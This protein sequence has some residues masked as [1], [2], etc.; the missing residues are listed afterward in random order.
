VRI[1][2]KNL[3]EFALIERLLR[4]VGRSGPPLPL[5]AGDDAALMPAL[6]RGRGVFTTDTMIENVHFRRDTAPPLALGIKALEASLSDLA[7]MGARPIAFFLSLSLPRR[8]PMADFDLLAT[9]LSRSARRARV[10]LAGG[11][12]TASPGPLVIS[13]GSLGALRRRGCLR[14]DGARPGDLLAVTGPL[15]ASATGLR[16]LSEGWRWGA[17][18][19]SGPARSP[20]A[21]RHARA[22]LRAHL[23]PRARLD[24]GPVAAERGWCRAGLDLSD[25][26]ASDLRRLCARS[27]VGARIE[28]RRVPIAPSARYWAGRWRVDPLQ[29]ALG[30]GEDYELLLALRPAAL[31]RWRRAG[32]PPPPLVLG[33]VVGLAEGVKEVGPGGRLS[34]LR[35]P[36]FRHF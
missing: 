4:R 3:G 20:A 18:G 6:A 5:G 34:P 28:T 24:V 17:R 14:R 36:S 23:M 29:L 21:R 22:A 9:G 30:G 11:D 10:A 19:V 2:L 8:Y 27:R 33:R 15:G 31:A 35:A 32:T 1:Q 7:A 25:G 16:L 12:T 13:V 26:L